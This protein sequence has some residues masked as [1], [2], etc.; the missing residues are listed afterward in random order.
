MFNER[1]ELSAGYV[2]PDFGKLCSLNTEPEMIR[3]CGCGKCPNKHGYSCPVPSF[4]VISIKVTKEYR[5]LENGLYIVTETICE[6]AKMFENPG[7]ELLSTQS[8]RSLST[9]LLH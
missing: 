4:E 5:K 8:I 6:Y 9:S 3:I 1:P 7:P 2:H